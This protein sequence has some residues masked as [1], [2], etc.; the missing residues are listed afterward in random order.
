MGPEIHFGLP[1]PGKWNG[2][3]VFGGGCGFAGSIV[4]AAQG[5][6]GALQMGYATVGTDT[7]YQA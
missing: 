3:F 7:G 5:F 2:K 6:Y 1:Y 4:N